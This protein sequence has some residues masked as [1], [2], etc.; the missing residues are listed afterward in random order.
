MTKRDFIAFQNFIDQI[1]K[2]TYPTTNSA[3]FA[4]VA[5]V[6]AVK[7][8][9]INFF[10]CNCN[11]STIVIYENVLLYLENE[12][13]SYVPANCTINGLSSTNTVLMQI[14]NVNKYEY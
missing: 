1:R 9:F 14:N 5:G 6:L 4:K 13:I 8:I 12:I 3:A 10:H 2:K 11:S 7:R